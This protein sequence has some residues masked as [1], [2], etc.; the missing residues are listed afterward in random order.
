VLK[1]LD[2]SGTEASEHLV[3]FI[4][5]YAWLSQ[6]DHP[7]V[8]RIHD[9]GFT[10]AHAYIAMEYFKRGDLRGLFSPQLTAQRAPG[11][12][13]EIAQA[14]HAIHLTGIVHR[15]IKSENIML[16]LDGSVALAD[17]GSATSMLHGR[18]AWALPRPGTATWSARPTT[19]AQS[20]PAAERLQPN[21]TFTA[22]A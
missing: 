12:V 7:H 8:I 18:H 16:R 9:Q 4:Q 1:I 10:D 19:S 11:V 21:Q 6:I 2:S 20:K 3:R 22:C 13:R 15:N 5:E 14:L 17:F